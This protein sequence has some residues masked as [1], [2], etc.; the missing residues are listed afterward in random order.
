MEHC[1]WRF[2]I[3]YVSSFIHLNKGSM[4][5]TAF[6][7]KDLDD[8]LDKAR[9]TMDLKLEKNF[10]ERLRRYYRKSFLTT[11]FFIQN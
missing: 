4:N 7:N 5:V 3:N 1:Q 11:L 9:I 8:T 2:V 10:M 6:V